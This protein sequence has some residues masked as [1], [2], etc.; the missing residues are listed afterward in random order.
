MNH[1]RAAGERTE[2]TNHEI[3]GVICRKNAEVA[4]TGPERI[5]RSERDALFEIIFV[6]HHAAFGAAASARGIDDC[7]QVF[8]FAGN[9]SRFRIAAHRLIEMGFPSLGT[10]EV[11]VCGR[12]GNQNSLDVQCG[13]SAG[14]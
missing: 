7:G 13:G 9:E 8:A 14:S 1:A 11:C 4:D 10:G 6:H 3:D 12:F 2:K 5:N